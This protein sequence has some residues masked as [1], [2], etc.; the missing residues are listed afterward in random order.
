MD[1]GRPPQEASRAEDRRQS[2]VETPPRCK[3]PYQPEAEARE[4]DLE[5]ERA[6]G[7]AD[8]LGDRPVTEGV[9]EAVVEIGDADRK[10][11]EPFEQRLGNHRPG[12]RLRLSRQ[13]HGGDDQTD[14]KEREGEVAENEEGNSFHP[15][16]LTSTKESPAV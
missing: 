13:R 1:T 2:H 5:L 10:E 9:A 3:H 8:Q 16:P 11:E 6:V 12:E 4:A 15:S 7:P 14:D